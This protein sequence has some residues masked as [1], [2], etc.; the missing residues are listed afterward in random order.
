MARSLQEIERDIQALAP[1]DRQQL[2][3]DLIADMDESEN[4]ESIEH[5]WR[6]EAQRRL[7]ELRNGSVT[8]VPAKD[9][10]ARARARLGDAG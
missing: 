7:S 1:T 10:F 4:S 3:R 6:V 9:V 5:A 8:P 2:L